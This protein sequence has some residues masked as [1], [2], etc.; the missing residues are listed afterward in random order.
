[1]LPTIIQLLPYITN[2]FRKL[3]L[4]ILASLLEIYLY[5]TECFQ[6]SDEVVMEDAEVCEWL[7]FGLATCFL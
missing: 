7:R 5:L 6:A 2:P 4:S 1:L 3:G